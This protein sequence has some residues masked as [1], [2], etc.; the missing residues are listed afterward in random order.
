M[1]SSAANMSDEL[2]PVCDKSIL[3][4]SDSSPGEDALQCE[5][6]CQSW[7]H[8][9][10]SGVTRA[11]YLKLAGSSDPFYCYIC[12]SNLFFEQTKALKSQIDSL[13][14]ELAGIK[15]NSNTSNSPLLNSSD[16]PLYSTVVS[17]GT[18]FNSCPDTNTTPG[19]YSFP[20]SHEP[21]ARNST[22]SAGHLP[23]T[24]SESPTIPQAKGSF[25]MTDKKFNLVFYGIPECRKGTKRADR[26]KHDLDMVSDI[27]SELINSIQADSIKDCVRLGKYNEQRRS[28]P[29]LVKFNR[30]ADV[31]N[32]LSKRK[33][34]DSHFL[35]K[36]VMS[37]DERKT[38]SI[39]LKERWNLTQSG[40]PKKDIRIRNS[41]IYIKQQLHGIVKNSVL[42][43][44]TASTEPTNESQM[45]GSDDSS[46]SDQ[47]D[48]VDPN[49]ASPSPMQARTDNNVHS[50]SS[51]SPSPT[52]ARTDNNVHNPTSGVNVISQPPSTS[53]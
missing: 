30:F 32:I 11:N 31:S 26:Y 47:L 22:S 4:P 9:R 16:G 34:L 13:S 1:P 43:H 14:E 8:R 20:T 42:Q 2:C 23:N 7:I 29:I 41:S 3:E 37:P 48:D 45:N 38:E 52:H 25:F 18:Q 15:S 49:S 40:V 44:I 33:D 17:S 51:A 28:R 21:H 19:S 10:C 6:P 36:P 35:I 12:L 5:G 27:T 46:L 53:S 50:T 24:T 39:L